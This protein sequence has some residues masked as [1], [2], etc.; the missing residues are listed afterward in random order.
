LNS[1]LEISLNFH[2]KPLPNH[3]QFLWGKLF[4]FLRSS[5]SYFISIFWSSG[6]TNLDRSKF[7]KIWPFLNRLKFWNGLNCF[8]PTPGTVAW[9]HRS[10]PAS[11]LFGATLTRVAR[12]LRGQPVASRRSHRTPSP[13]PDTWRRPPT[14]PPTAP[15]IIK[16]HRPPLAQGFLPAP[17]F[18]SQGPRPSPA[19]SSSRRRRSK[20][21]PAVMPALSSPSP[22]S[23]A[24]SQFSRHLV[25]PSLSSLPPTAAGSHCHSLWPPDS[26]AAS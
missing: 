19:S 20:P 11:P 18:S 15:P 17:P 8:D 13:T 25:V 7:G 4:I 26:A 21:G 6:R 10:A 12:E 24:L 5:K 3:K 1:N 14:P 23:T 2:S 16:R 9:A 22:V